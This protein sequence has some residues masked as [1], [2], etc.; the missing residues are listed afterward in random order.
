MNKRVF[1]FCAATLVCIIARAQEEQKIELEEVVVTDS[2]F[3]LKR[4]NSG[5]T[6]IKIT[7]EEIENNQ[8]K[9]LV[10]L[11]NAKSGIEINGSRSSAGQNLGYYIRGG[12]NRQVLVMI[13]GIQVNDPSQ[14]ANDF[15]LRL[16]DLAQVESV[17]I[18]KG[19]AS[20]L[21]GNNAA[22]AVISI[23]TKKA[24]SKGISANFLTSV[25]TNQSAKDENYNLADFSNS[26]NINGTVGKVT[27]LAGFANQ[28][29]DGLSAVEG[30]ER[31]PFSRINTNVKVGYQVSDQFSVQI[32]GNYDK[33]RA[34]FDNSF[35]IGDADFN[36][37]SKQYRAGI[38][39]EFKYGKG[40]IH[41]N[42]AYN[43]IE[44][45]LNSSF[46]ATYKGNSTVLDLFNKYTFANQF[47]TIVGLNYIKSEADFSDEVDFT[48]TD[49]YA[50]VVWVSDFGLN[51]NVG[52]RLNNHS[53][54]GSHFTYNLNPSYS[55]AIQDGYLK[56]FGSYSTSYIAPS[57]SQLFG[58]FGAYPE[59]EPEEDRTI[60]G[61]LEYKMRKIRISALYFTRNHENFIDYVTVN[62]DTFE[63]GYRNVT[64]DFTVNG[65]EVELEASPLEKLTLSANYT[66]T[67]NKDK[68]ALRIPK[69]KINALV[70][71]RFSDRT[72][73]SVGYQ[74]TGKRL[75]TN[76]T[77]FLNEELD[78]FSIVNFDIS[79]ELI[80][81]RLKILLDAENLLNEKY[82][83]VIGYNTR[84]RNFRLGLNIRF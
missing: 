66:F 52:G 31:D 34:D 79:H 81:N 54:Y 29:T 53:E 49:P 61:G 73:A 24:S 37:L 74:Y 5:K 27:Y 58:P 21:Y 76:F 22:T 69:H 45:E 65:V 60:E 17:E 63:G 35:P 50:N 2:R 20:T 43:T 15:D 59:L 4:E 55:Y 84:G 42:A 33:F 77:T 75:D 70:G 68:V 40:S 41:L 44:R 80:H 9:T 14:I 57:L 47:H 78:S 23:T 67:E 8:G 25:G 39:P 28:Y 3:E 26:A 1:S 56:L 13:D 64:E 51:L 18:I 62:P 72:R 12:N 32:Y 7:A 11:I 30:E 82:T 83:E 48:I 10:S 6:V 19:A 38:A 36:S 46:P 16:I 71:Y